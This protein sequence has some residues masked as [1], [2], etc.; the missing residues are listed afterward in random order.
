MPQR[1]GEQRSIGFKVGN[2]IKVARI[3]ATIKEST[4]TVRLLASDSEQAYDIDEIIT[5]MAAW[6]HGRM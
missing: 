1:A 2:D 4:E 3:S 6:P 5:C